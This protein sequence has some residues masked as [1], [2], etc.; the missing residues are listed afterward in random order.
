MFAYYFYNNNQ[1]IP[2]MNF[3]DSEILI[4]ISR[5]PNLV[6][7]L[8]IRSILTIGSRIRARSHQDF[9]GKNP[10][11]EKRQNS[12]YHNF[13]TTHWSIKSQKGVPPIQMTHF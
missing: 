8:R 12:N 7:K 6:R 10:K 1:Y 3:L 11:I 2:T 9:L 4:S 5:K 13:L